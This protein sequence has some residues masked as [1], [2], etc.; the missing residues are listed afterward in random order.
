MI[1]SIQTGNLKIVGIVSDLGRVLSEGEIKQLETAEE[2]IIDEA[3]YMQV[4]QKKTA[5]LL[6]ACTE[7]GA[8]SA[9]ASDE[10]VKKCRE[11]GEYLGY[12]FQM[13]DDIFDYFKEMNIGKP[14]GND[15]REGKVTL[16]LL[17]TLRT[18]PSKEMSEHYIKII[19][20]KEFSTENVEALITFAKENGG[21]EYAELRMKEYRDKAI[22]VLMTM[23]ESDARENLIQ[24]AD[25]IIER[26][27]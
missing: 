10:M 20:N 27:K 25:Y 19:Q 23:P 13:K 24:L 15:I 5:R 8:I 4:I 3:C 7:I 17:Y 18:A 12:C 21:I 14:T 1:R 22:E 16:P 9:D 6:S 2:S 11:F 26:K